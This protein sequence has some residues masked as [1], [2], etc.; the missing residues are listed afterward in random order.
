M[1]GRPADP[2]DS[3]AGSSADPAADFQVVSSEHIFHGYAFDVHTDQVRMPDGTVA[4]R[5]VVE[6]L[7][8]VAVLALDDDE[9]VSMV[10]QYRHPIR[11]H[12]LEL[13]AGLLD[14]D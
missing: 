13:P 8:A 14:V 12:L 11:Q 9:Q 10:Y 4:K 1:T 3:A 7:G 6:H 5:D 2:A